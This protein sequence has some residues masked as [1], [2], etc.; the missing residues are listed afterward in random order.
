MLPP[1]PPSKLQDTGATVLVLGATGGVG[2][3]VTAK[4]LERGYKVRALVRNVAKAQSTLGSPPGVEYVQG[5]CRY[6]NQ[7]DTPKV[8]LVM[9]NC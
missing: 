1:Q 7:I 4:L 5:D 8:G 6:M 2:Q 9:N 3:I